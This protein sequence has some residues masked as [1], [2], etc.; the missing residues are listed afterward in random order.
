MMDGGSSPHL[1]HPA[2]WGPFVVVGDG[3]PLAGGARTAAPTGFP[4]RL[5]NR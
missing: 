2:A 1:A 5:A 4:Q 3:G